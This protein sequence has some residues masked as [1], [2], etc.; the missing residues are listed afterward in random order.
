M[1]RIFGEMRQIAFVVRDLDRALRYWTEVMGVGPFFLLRDLVPEN[2][3]YR[4]EPSP[5]PRITLALGNSGDVQ[6][7]LVH[8]HDDRPSAYRD[9]LAARHEGS[10]HVSSWVTRA[11][12]GPA[13]ERILASGVKIAHEGS[14]PG[15]GIRFVYF[16]TGDGP[17]GLLYEMSEAKEPPVCDMMLMIRDE[18]RTWDG[19]DP[20][21][22]VSL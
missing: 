11:E 15:S 17:G 19:A 6:I 13:R 5:A 7:E 10:Q 21:R 9:F 4:G 16:E 14:M 3:H 18:A 8:Q 1:S 12:Y 22:E 2:F 20:V